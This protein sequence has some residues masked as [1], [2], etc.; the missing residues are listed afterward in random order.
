MPPRY[1]NLFRRG[2]SNDSRQRST[3]MRGGSALGQ[4]S[5][6][7]KDLAAARNKD[8]AAIRSIIRTHNRMLFRLARSILAS[9]DDAE[10]AVQA[11]YVRAFTGLSAFRGEARLGTWL[12]RIVINE[13]L[14]RI[15]RA[16]PTMSIDAI[17][18]QRVAEVIPFPMIGAAPDP[19]RSMAQ[20]Q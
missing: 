12:G 1:G 2:A 16:R 15:R 5:E 8:E 18:V 17:E 14:G 4:H 20:H 9:E 11:A 19:E 13:A 3:I 6:T 7:D 10:D